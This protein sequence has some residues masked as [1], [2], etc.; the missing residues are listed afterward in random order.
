M[1]SAGVMSPEVREVL[2]SAVK[3]STLGLKT[4]DEETM[5]DIVQ[6][7]QLTALFIEAIKDLKSE[8]DELKAKLGDK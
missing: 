5:Y 2:P 8:I 4:G 7:D 3:Q 1:K 6:Y